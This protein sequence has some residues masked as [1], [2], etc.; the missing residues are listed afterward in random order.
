MCKDNS[1]AGETQQLIAIQDSYILNT[2][3]Q[4]LGEVWEI[5]F[6]VWNR[7]QGIID[8]ITGEF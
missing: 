1:E 6:M 7:Y 5:I 2:Y 8:I 3:N 4:K